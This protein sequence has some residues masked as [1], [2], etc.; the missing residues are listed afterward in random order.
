M[1]KKKKKIAYNIVTIIILLGGIAWVCSHFVHLGRIEYTDNAQ[2]RRNLIPINAHVQGYIKE[3]RFSDFDYVDKGDTLVILEDDEYRL[4]LQKAMANHEKTTLDDATLVAAISTTESNVSV[5]ESAI[6][7]NRVRMEQKKNDYERYEQLLSQKSVTRQ[8]YD[9][10]KA[11]YEAAKAKYEMMV[12]QRKSTM[13]MK[14]EQ[15]QRLA[16]NSS[17]KAATQAAVDLAQL[18]LSYTVITAPCDGVTS[19]K[20]IE[21]GQLIQPGQQLL[22]IVEAT[23]VWV[24]A[25]YKEKQT[26][27]ITVG[28]PVKIK[29]DAVP[30]ITYKGV[31]ASLSNAT[32]AQ[33]SAI[34]Q[35]NAA[36]NFVKVQQRIPVK[37]TF[38][39]DN[40]P[41]DLER[42]RS[43]MN[44]E[45]EVEY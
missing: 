37:I 4:L 30:R 38:T 7:E 20:G 43:G 40:R 23:N 36:G 45:C 25:N 18:N 9:N 2:I 22:S 17:N 42:L 41:E 44:V 5:S 39:D 28:M 21:I 1:N 12:R 32:G 13:L 14:E 10:A 15:T 24:I 29:V 31:V 8:Q 11:D 26:A 6:E 35:D 34:P 33:Y 19:R 27:N 16:Q 3:I